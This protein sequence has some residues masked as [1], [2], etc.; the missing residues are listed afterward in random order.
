MIEAPPPSEEVEAE[1]ARRQ[2]AREARQ[3][4]VWSFL[5]LAMLAAAALMWV[6]VVCAVVL[7]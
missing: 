7:L 2:R 6:A 4:R 1:A 3:D 5:V